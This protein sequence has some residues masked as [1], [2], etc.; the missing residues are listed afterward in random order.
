MPSKAEKPVCN[1]V[2][3]TYSTV[4]NIQKDCESVTLTAMLTSLPQSHLGTARRYPHGTEWTRLL[5]VL[6]TAQCQLHVQTSP[7]T[8]LRVRYIHTAVPHVLYVTLHCRISQLS[9]KLP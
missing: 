8:L 1:T 7:V 3:C 2:K 9:K 4:V 5:R 6:L